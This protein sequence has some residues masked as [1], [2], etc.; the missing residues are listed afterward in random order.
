MQRDPFLQVLK[1]R[2]AADFS[3]D[4]E[5]VRIPLDHYL[6]ELDVIAFVDLD[7]GAVNDRVALALAVLVVNHRN[8]SLAVHDDQI[9]GFGL[10]RLQTDEADCSVGLGLQPRL[11]GDSR[12]RTADV[13]GT[14]RELRS[15][16]AAHDAYLPH[17]RYGI[18]NL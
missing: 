17:R 2:R 10:N 11:F 5:G 16:F 14:H 6:S 4:G 9:A 13:E 15:R 1:L 12:C 7:L 18:A 3:Q 8:R